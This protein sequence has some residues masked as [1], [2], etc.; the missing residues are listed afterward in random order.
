MTIC[1][2]C[3]LLQSAQK[4]CGGSAGGEIALGVAISP[5]SVPGHP[6]GD[7][8][9][10][11][12]RQYPRRFKKMEYPEIQVALLA[13]CFQPLGACLATPWRSWHMISAFINHC[14][15]AMHIRASILPQR[16]VGAG[17]SSRFT[18][19]PMQTD[20]SSL[21]PESKSSVNAL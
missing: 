7:K 14:C 12:P 21:R 2:T 17:A 13:H 3:G 16:P 18:A 11:Q 20:S 10:Y 15:F 5:R 8:P 9:L 1:W 6:L 19:L 4:L